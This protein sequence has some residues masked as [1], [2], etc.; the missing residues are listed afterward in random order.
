MAAAAATTSPGT[1]SSIGCLQFP[2]VVLVQTVGALR[3]LEIN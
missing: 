1:V 2:W 3:R